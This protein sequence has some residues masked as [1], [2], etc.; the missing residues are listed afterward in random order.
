[1][2]Y[3]LE[4]TRVVAQSPTER[5]FHIFYQ[6]CA[7]AVA[8]RKNDQSVLLGMD[9]SDLEE[10][11]ETLR[12]LPLDNAK[13]F[14]Y[15]KQGNCFEVRGVNDAQTFFATLRSFKRIG[16]P[17]D[18]I[19]GILQ[20]LTSIL[21]L[22]NI[23]LP[24]P[25]ADTSPVFLNPDAR[26]EIDNAAEVLGLDSDELVES[27]QY[28]HVVVIHEKTRIPL[29][30]AQ[31]YDVR[32]TL[33]KALYGR[34]FDWIVGEVNFHLNMKDTDSSDGR[35]P[36]DGDKE[37][38][39]EEEEKKG[40]KE[41]EEVGFTEGMNSIGVLD[42][43]GFEMN[44]TNSL[45]QFFIN[46]ANEKLQQFFIHHLFKSEQVEYR[47]EGVYVEKVEFV[48]NQVCLDLLEGSSRAPGMILMLDEEDALAA[49]N[50][51]RFL[52]RC[53]ETFFA[54]YTHTSSTS[55]I[56]GGGRGGR[57]TVPINTHTR[58]GRTPPPLPSSH[59][60]RGTSLLSSHAG[61]ARKS[62]SS[63]VRPPPLPQQS[64][65]P[66]FNPCFDRVL[67]NADGFCV[68]HYAG[69]VEYDVNGFLRKNKDKFSDTQAEF[70]RSSKLSLLQSMFNIETA[71]KLATKTAAVGFSSDSTG[72]LPSSGDP[73][74]GGGDAALVQQYENLLITQKAQESA[75]K[76]QLNSI[77]NE[78]RVQ[79]NELLLTLKM[80]QPHFIRCIRPNSEKV[81]FHFES[82]Q[83]LWQMKSAG[84][85]QAL[86]IRRS[87]YPHR[88]THADFYRRYKMIRLYLLAEVNEVIT[89]ETIREVGEEPEDANFLDLC[90]TLLHDIN[91]HP[92]W[93]IRALGFDSGCI[94]KGASKVFF[95][96]TQNTVLET[97][98]SKGFAIASTVLSQQLSS[99]S[100]GNLM[101]PNS[102]RGQDENHNIDSGESPSANNKGTTASGHGI[103]SRDVSKS[104]RMTARVVEVDV[105]NLVDHRWDEWSVPRTF[106]AIKALTSVKQTL[107]KQHSRLMKKSEYISRVENPL[108]QSQCAA[109][110]F[111]HQEFPI[112]NHLLI[113]DIE[114]TNMIQALTISD[115][116]DGAMPGTSLKDWTV[117]LYD[118][119]TVSRRVCDL[120]NNVLCFTGERFHAYPPT[121]AHSIMQV[122]HNDAPLRDEIYCHLIKQ[123]SLPHVDGKAVGLLHRS[124]KNQILCW[125]LL[126]LVLRRFLPIDTDTHKVLLSHISVN[127]PQTLS[128][129]QLSL[130]ET[131]SASWDSEHA[132]DVDPTL[133]IP[134]G[135]VEDIATAC[136]FAYLISFR[137]F[138]GGFTVTRT[139]LPSYSQI[140]KVMQNSTVG[141]SHFM[142]DSLSHDVVYYED[143]SAM[144]SSDEE[145]D[146]NELFNVDSGAGGSD[147]TS[148]EVKQ[149]DGD[150]EGDEALLEK[151]KFCLNCGTNKPSDQKFCFDCGSRYLDCVSND[152]KKKFCGE[153][154]EKRGATAFCLECGTRH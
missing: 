137:D 129:S 18:K 28:K 148:G 21:V 133:Q 77:G 26:K 48:D 57:A 66:T 80:T 119:E 90:A 88:R 75:R 103:L 89:P 102:P 149:E 73:A 8:V 79:L 99:P 120:F 145:E 32:D 46:Y 81:A 91:M 96:A 74:I 153:C 78:F 122:G 35:D 131:V 44:E 27:L 40:E 147:P 10:E 130:Y 63:A 86:R 140:Q 139:S 118:P 20:I 69:D 124:Q 12:S 95:T 14:H 107:L 61:G 135:T 123:T 100:A 143:M 144:Y 5:N 104:S 30:Y 3:L 97:L 146:E 42:I 98:R 126:F 151:L 142:S 23:S 19:V 39:E 15:L 92:S 49:M 33:S 152:S 59:A 25:G 150:G 53:M 108:F 116:T 125:K 62:D 41:R 76:K 36:G 94:A 13:E 109:L 154:G 43:F 71:T 101:D 52:N 127:L 58:G 87:G 1:M 17:T 37:E 114:S 68:K 60:P 121:C 38:E 2:T 93:S 70:F 106:D 141:Y 84:L 54:D 45:E 22:G 82:N 47:N 83:V 34:L 6:L 110:R 85:V 24:H 56:A 64:G 9:L 7:A 115:Q 16:F 128:P 136:W 50:D 55:A 65:G 117:Q 105:E 51:K 132:V 11:V 134:F 31:A 67:S 112:P 4:K 111:V 29:T 138:H 113:I 72:G